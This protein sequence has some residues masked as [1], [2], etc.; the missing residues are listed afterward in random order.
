MTKP[1]SIAIQAGGA[2]TIVAEQMSTE[3]KVELLA[4]LELFSSSWSSSAILIQEML[5]MRWLQRY[6][7]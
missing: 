5:W 6:K 4:D 3:L 1:F 2:G 7:Y